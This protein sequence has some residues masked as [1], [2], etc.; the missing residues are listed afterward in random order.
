MADQNPP[1]MTVDDL[2]KRERPGLRLRFAINDDMQ[3]SRI[4][5][6]F[7]NPLGKTNRDIATIQDLAKKSSPEMFEWI[8]NKF[9]TGNSEIPI[10]ETEESFL[11]KYNLYIKQITET[12]EY[13]K[14]R[15]ETEKHLRECQT[16]WEQNYPQTSEIIHDLT[17][18][19]LNKSMTVYILH[20]SLHVGSQSFGKNIINWGHRE[21]WPNYT[22]VY[23]WHE[24]MHSYLE[25][26]DLA[27]AIIQLIADNELRTR[28]NG[29][30]YGQPDSPQRYEGH[31]SLFPLMDQILPAWQEY[32]KLETSKRNI[33]DFIEKV[34]PTI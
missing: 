30:S 28:L 25:N 12:P 7:H 18:I 8:N 34:K 29:G 6:R 3:I 15:Q 31:P 32:M 19:D 9:S 4:I 5:W 23:L 14:I 17:R 13:Q 27:H 1:L 10:G 20:P 2:E 16:Q 26:S 33:Y 11:Q 21:N 22:T 24:I